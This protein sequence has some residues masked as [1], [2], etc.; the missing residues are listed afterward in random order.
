MV[1]L[2]KCVGMDPR[3]ALLA[4]CNSVW[5]LTSAPCPSKVVVFLS[6]CAGVDFHHALLASDLP[7][8]MGA[9]LP[10]KLFKL[11]GNLAQVL[12]L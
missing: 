6:T 3:I 2:S 7:Q 1:F 9:R 8:A 4:V 10:G 12:I 5:R 11:H